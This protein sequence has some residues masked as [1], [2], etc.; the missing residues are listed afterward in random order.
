MYLIEE[1][2]LSLELVHVAPW[3]SN[4]YKAYG[5]SS[6]VKELPTVEGIGVDRPQLGQDQ[7]CSSFVKRASVQPSHL[8][9][10]KKNI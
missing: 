10:L 3:S 4:W 7:A 5:D 2:R 8:S 6:I 1:D 9:S